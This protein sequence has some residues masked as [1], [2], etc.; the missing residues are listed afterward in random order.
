MTL[1][2]LEEALQ[3]HQRTLALKEKLLGP[4]HPAVL[5]SLNNL[6]MLMKELG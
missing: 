6:G 3:I 4:E 1:G 5:Q 2:R